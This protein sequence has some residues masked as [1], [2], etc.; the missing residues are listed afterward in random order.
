[1]TGYVTAERLRS[2]KHPDPSRVALV[3][4]SGAVARHVLDSARETLLASVRADRRARGWARVT[5]A[6]P[7]KFCAMLASRGAV[8]SATSGVFQAHDHCGCTLEPAF[9]E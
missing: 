2:L 7:C 9:F 1:V 6:E 5:S 8:Y 3:R 4:V